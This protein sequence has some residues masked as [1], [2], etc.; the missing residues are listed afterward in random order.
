[1]NNNIPYYNAISREVMVKRIMKYAGEEYS[2][3]AF[4]ANDKES[5]P[6]VATKSE[7]TWSEGTDPSSS[8]GQIPPKFM[9]EKPSF[10]KTSF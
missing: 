9:G 2:F 4:K 3:E 8:F 1:M 5:L 10:S 6:S 7:W